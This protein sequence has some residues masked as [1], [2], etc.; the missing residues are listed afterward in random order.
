M[1]I[2]KLDQENFCEEHIRETSHLRPFPSFLFSAIR[3]INIPIAC[4][5][6]PNE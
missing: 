3:E 5:S 4:F 2:Q 1:Y 6:R